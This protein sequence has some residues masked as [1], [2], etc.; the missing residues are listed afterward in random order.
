MV[1]VDDGSLTDVFPDSIKHGTNFGYGAAI[2]TG[3]KNCH[4]NT[5]M[6]MDG[7]GQHSLNDAL[8]LASAWKLM[9]VD[10]LIGARSIGK[11]SLLRIFG[12]KFLN[13]TA[14]LI[15]TYWLR[16]LNSGM[17]IFKKSIV[18]G[19]IPILCKTFS[20]TTSLTLSMLL[21]G[22][23]VEWFP[24]NVQQRPHG[25]S[26]VKVIKD[27][28]VTLYYILKIGFALRTRKIRSVWRKLKSSLR[29]SVASS[30][31]I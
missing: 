31:A 21:D 14:S 9:K 12:R 24:I 15:C 23:K 29:G 26:R 2:M 7:D 13:W 18:T 28:W 30:G 1:V 8:R 4:R 22:Y 20:F 27:G 25:K 10:M 6:V 17:R 16:D 19:Y 11:E 5:V 3:V